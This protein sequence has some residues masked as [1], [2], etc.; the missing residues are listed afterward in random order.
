MSLVWVRFRPRLVDPLLRGAREQRQVPK[1]ALHQHE[2]SCCS[3]LGQGTERIENILIY[4]IF[5]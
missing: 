3:E 5:I 1:V 4:F 2:Y